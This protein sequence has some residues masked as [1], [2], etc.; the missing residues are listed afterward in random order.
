M[1]INKYLLIG[2]LLF[3]SNSLWAQDKDT[4]ALPGLLNLQK[5]IEVALVNN[6]DL[7][8]AQNQL[9]QSENS[10][11]AGNA[12]LLPSLTANGGTEYSVND[13]EMQFVNMGE[14]PSAGE[15]INIDG[16]ET[17]T[18]NG[19]VRM[20][21]TLFD[22]FG[23]VYTYKKLKDANDLQQTLFRQQ[24][25]MTI[26][27][28]AQQYYEVARSQQNWHLAKSSL[29]ISKDRYVR[30]VDQK[31]FGQANQLDLLNA[32]VDM[33][34][35]ST[36]L[37]Q[38]EQQFVMAVKDLNV[39]LG[40]AVQETFEVDDQIAFREDINMEDVLANTMTNNAAL[41]TQQKQEGISEWDMKITKARKMP[42]ISAYG[43]YGYSHMDTDAGQILY[44]ESKGFTGGLTASF[45]IFNGRQQR[46]AEQNAK[47][48]LMSEQERSRQIMA[49]VER[50]AANAI[51][52]YQ[53]KRRIVELQK[54][55][56]EQAELNFE[57]TKEMYA[58]GRATSIEFR[59]A[60]ENLLS[61][62]NRYSDAQY[63]AK[64][65]EF[66][67]LQLSGSLIGDYQQ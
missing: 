61:V 12:G 22:G 31:A 56:L 28:V 7:K 15:V 48:D 38:A 62:A 32:E 13:T 8:I 30:A 20:D 58:L 57:T 44:N 10:A 26:F 42:S 5:A 25:E 52:D 9:K 45:N 65:A 17:L 60:Q 36:A 2:G 34:S 50:D 21:Y 14:T 33:N 18:Y 63:Q 64:V 6:Y 23:N 40:V 49:E 1:K 41:V 67:L 11:T 47:L 19:N 51:T 3:L 37:L 46:T 55:S 53:Y 66:Y 59:T 29:A 35:D 54:S 27:Q 24:M 39:I 4:T 43:S 16:A